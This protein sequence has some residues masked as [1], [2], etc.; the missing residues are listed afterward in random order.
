[1]Y[2]MDILITHYV[3]NISEKGH[4]IIIYNHHHY[5]NNNFKCVLININKFIYSQFF[6]SHW[7]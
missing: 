6:F 7:H 4:L 3:P 5:N 2:P 1:M